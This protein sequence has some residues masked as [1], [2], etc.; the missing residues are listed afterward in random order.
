MDKT[1]A[2]RLRLSR[3]R[4]LR[5][6]AGG[7]LGLGAASF[8]GVARAGAEAPASGNFTRMFP[9]LPPFCEPTSRLA[10]AL[11][12]LGRPGGAMD[13][14]DPLAAGPVRLITDLSLSA[15]NPNAGLPNGRVGLTFLGQFLDHDLTFDATSQLGVPAVPQRSPNARR[16]A[17][18]LDSL[19]GAG[20]VVDQLIYDRADRAKLRIESG[21]LFEDVPRLADGK[22]LI[23]D[24]RNDENLMIAGLH[25]AMVLFHNRVVDQVRAGGVRDPYA[26]FAR[27][28]RIVTWHYQWIVLHELLPS[29]VGQAMVDG[30]LGRGRFGRD[31]DGLATAMP[32]EFQGA[33]YRFAHSI[34][35]PSYRA[36]LHGDL[37]RPFFGLV[38]D[39]AADGELD[40]SDLRGGARAPRRFIGWQT[41]FD[42]GDGQLKPRK[43]IDTRISTP[44]FHLSLGAIAD[45]TLPT[46][47]P[48]RNLLRQMT[49]GMP[50]GQRIAEELGVPALAAADFPELAGYGLGLERSTPLWY[51]VLREAFLATGGERLGPVGG[52]IV[53]ETVVGLMRSDPG[54][55]LAQDPG[56]TPELPGRGG[57]GSF[58]MVD[59]LTYARVDPVS[60][61]Q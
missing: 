38:F 34:V 26:V 23:A 14:N 25:A 15:N 18:D 5:A 36:N 4:V 6:L 11:Y 12:D 56:W 30:V 24:P 21:G 22:A 13:A 16:P 35:R 48:Q 44:L 10:A 9:N 17:L 3:R 29:F 55:W 28:R 45:G 53:A 37:G 33:A 52:R 39:P 49:W 8:L 32:V 27:A 57:A 20:P 47:L 59:L 42:F 2:G 40:P 31:R 7:T 50:S 41:F 43:L 61:G 58:D 46:A 1:S 51:Y 60:R 19:Y 54:S